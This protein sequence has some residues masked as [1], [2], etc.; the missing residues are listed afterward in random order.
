M[1]GQATPT[2]S[3]EIEIPSGERGTLQTLKLMRSITRRSKKSWPIQQHA[4]SIVRELSDKDYLGELSAVHRWV[5]D[6]IRYVRDVD[7]V[8][9]L[10]TPEKTLEIGQGDCDDKSMLAAAL[11]GSIGHPT[12]FVAIGVN[13]PGQ[14]GGGFCHVY[15]ESKLGDKWVSVETTEPVQLGW[16]PPRVSKR[17]VVHN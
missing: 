15:V 1:A 5:R 4:L 12:R 11:L 6:N 8:E 17:M 13:R 7:D 14:V 16:V 2:T 3:R 10:R 9:T